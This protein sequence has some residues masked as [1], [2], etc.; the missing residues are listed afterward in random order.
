[1][2]RLMGFRVVIAVKRGPVHLVPDQ[3]P[4]FFRK[5]PSGNPL[6]QINFHSRIR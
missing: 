2:G 5:R 4:G 3:K 6:V 1:M